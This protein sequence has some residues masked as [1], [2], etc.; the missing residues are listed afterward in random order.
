MK[1]PIV[2]ERTLAGYLIGPT[3]QRARE[4]DITGEEA[5]IRFADVEEHAIDPESRATLRCDLTLRSSTAPLV[6]A[7]LKRPEVMAAD[8]HELKADAHR[9][10]LNRGF[11]YY[12]TC[13]LRDVALWET[14]AGPYEQ[15]PVIYHN[16]AE[17][18]SESYYAPQCREEIAANWRRFLDKAEPLLEL[19]MG[20][21]AKDKPLPPHIDD[22]RKKILAC[23]HDAG[24]RLRHACEDDH[25]RKKAL[26][27]FRHQFGVDLQLDPNGPREKFAKE[28]DQVGVIS[29]FVVASRLLLYQALTAATLPGGNT[30]QLDDL[31]VSK[32]ATDP[33][34]IKREIESLLAHARDRTNDFETTLTPT[35]VDEIA[36]APSERP[37]KPGPVWSDLV[38]HIR[39]QDWSGPGDY[40][41]GLYESLL[42]DE[43][44]H[45]TGVHYTPD[46][47]AELVTTYAVRDPAD[48]VLDPASGGGTFLTM[49]YSRKR[50]LGSNHEQSL[51]EIYGVELAEFAASLSTLVLAV[52]DP[53]AHSAYPREI[54]SDFFKIHPGESTPLIL[55]DVGRLSVPMGLDAV[56]GNPPY[57]RFELRENSEKNAIYDALSKNHA[58]SGLAY[59]D[60]TGK[61]DLWAFFVAHSYVFLKDGGRLAFVLPWNLLSSSYGDAVIDFLGR[62]FLVDL[63]LDSKVERWFAAKQNTLLLFARRAKA[64]D[65]LFSSELNPNIP[66]DHKIRFV[67]LKQPVARLLDLD[68]PRGKRAEDLLDA[69]LDV[70]SDQGED[71][72]WDIRIIEQAEL[73]MRTR[74]DSAKEWE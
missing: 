16:L 57:V 60:F 43:H 23:G 14:T 8:A 31:E 71:L 25:F 30:F 29:S 70:G 33:G 21:R 65:N 5:F 40:V 64:P 47:L 11:P 62:Y 37:T 68:S 20:E 17:E 7:E 4:L 26:S 59:P 52:S 36:F 15:V 53:S 13:N 24:V 61:A 42:E 18:L 67:R 73:V 2:D 66:V 12:L 50:Q 72:R 32:R 45:L 49:A 35:L 27:A 39:S 3:E 9:K 74:S 55:P 28:T 69:I 56:I 48:V 6:S 46:G 63:I 1:R 41:P 54:V 22:L 51:A 34:R 58:R 10:A 44:R 19:A 38:E